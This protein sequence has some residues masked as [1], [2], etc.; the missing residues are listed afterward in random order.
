MTNPY[1]NHDANRVAQ[2]T[3]AL[4]TQINNIADE[5]A[6]GFDRLPTEAELKENRTGFGVA[7]GTANIL[8][9]VLPYT[10]TLGDGFNFFV[11]FI[12]TST[13]AATINVN[14]TGTKAIVNS[15]GSP[16]TTGAM[17][18][19][20]IGQLAYDLPNDRYI[21]ISNNSAWGKPAGT[22]SSSPSEYCP[23]YTYVFVSTTVWRIS[24]FD[25]IN[26]F[27]VGRRLKFVDGSNEYF[28][29][30]T[31]SVFTGGNTDMTMS[32]ESGDVLTNTIG[33]VCLTTGTAGWSAI[34]GDPFSG[35]PI[36]GITSGYI[37]ATKYWVI[38]GNGGRL[39]YSVNAGVSWVLATT[40]T[41]EDLADVAYN[42][43][44]ESFVAVGRA[45]V[46]LYSTNGTSW[47]LDTT[48]LPAAASPGSGNDDCYSV[49]YDTVT[50]SWG[51][52]IQT[53]AAPQAQVLFSLND[54]TSWSVGASSQ[55]G[56]PENEAK[57]RMFDSI[58]N[59]DDY[60]LLYPVGQDIYLLQD[61]TDTT[62]TITINLSS[63]APV[64]AI[65]GLNV[66]GTDRIVNCHIDGDIYSSLTLIDGSIFGN[67]RINDVV[68]SPLHNRAIY[69][70]DNA[71]IV[72]SETQFGSGSFTA[73]QNGFNPLTHLLCI[74]WDEDDGIFIV[75][76]SNGQICRSTNGTN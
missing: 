74:G 49:V 16:L 71:R 59:G 45:G 62:G 58:E 76:A 6:L 65:I 20:T 9:V 37:G 10:P 33:Q 46:Y 17:V 36:R 61:P 42:S 5:I 43:T 50:T 14:S 39:A 7:T 2:G 19:G 73:R 64:S 3:R 34:S 25:V 41:S 27:Y 72:S 66:L 1:F 31:A 32:M 55:S 18:S 12:A 11:R 70:G 75:G 23:G 13:G 51:V 44:D 24:G 60:Q 38:V 63:Q 40:G 15:D 29:T 8:A 4:D 22:A 30:I 52:M 53:T 47:A 67:D 56:N 26:L 28:G 54:T 68:F 48:K 21:L 35:T 69:I 57:M